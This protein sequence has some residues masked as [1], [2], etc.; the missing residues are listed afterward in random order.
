VTIKELRNLQLRAATQARALQAGSV[1]WDDF[2]QEFASVRD[3]L[4]AKLFDLLEHQPQH[5]GTLGVRDWEYGDHL[6]YVRLAI[7]ELESAARA[8]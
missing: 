7:E 6:S 1:S 4:I 2:R 8:V 3:P 5:G